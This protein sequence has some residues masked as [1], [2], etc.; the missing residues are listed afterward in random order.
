[1]LREVSTGQLTIGMYVADL[2]RPWLGTP[3][4]VQ[5]FYIRSPDDVARV[6]KVCQRVF[7][8]PRRYDSRLVAKPHAPAGGRVTRTD[9]HGPVLWLCDQRVPEIR[10][11]YQDSATVNDELPAARIALDDGVGAFRRMWCTISAKRNVPLTEIARAID[12][13]VDS[14]LRNKD[15]LVAL[16]RLQRTDQHTHEH[17]LAMAVWGSIMGRQLGLPPEKIRLLALS[18]SLVDF[19]KS[20]LP[21]SL[22]NK[23]GELTEEDWT[24]LRSHVGHSLDML[25][26]MGGGDDEIFAVIRWHHERMDGSGYPDGLSG[27]DIPMFARIAGIL[28]SYD[29]MI[30]PRTVTRTRSSFDAL[31]ELQ[32]LSPAR[33]QSELVE[34]FSQ[35][36][37]IFPTGT[38]VELN[39]GE[40]AIVF[41]QSTGRRL[42]PKVLMILDAQKRR[43]DKLVVVDLNAE[44]ETATWIAR[45]LPLGAY[46][47][48][49]REFFL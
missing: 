39:S 43:R 10:V 12:P 23:A 26:N 33:Y 28:D 41:S 18:C 7:V 8:D 44:N 37:G 17:C 19:G 20:Q 32:D 29:A 6:A 24:I 49:A 27:S 3:F 34:Q 4:P 2:D 47:V 22:L 36:V 31:M 9:E 45:E 5:G 15:A 40:V 38:L 11:D 1:M 42:R 14:I 13:L 25:E 16:M 30:S 46:A 48:D 35:A 21:V